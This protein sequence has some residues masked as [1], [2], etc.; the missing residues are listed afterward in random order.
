MV[1]LSIIIVNWN[2]GDLLRRCIKSVIQSPPSISYDITI[3]DN[4]STDDSVR[5]LH[6]NEV[7]ELLGGAILRVIENTDNR[8]F[9]KAN[10]QAIAAGTAPLLFLLNS[11]AEVTP[12]AIDRLISTLKSD[13]HIGACGP[14]L[15]NSDGSLQPSVSRNPP[16]AWEILVS[17][18]RL[19]KFIP[20][21][22][23][24]ELLLDSYWDHRRRRR[25]NFLTAAAILAKREMI[26]AVGGFD[27]RFHMYGE[28]NEW[29]LRIVR[30]GWT[31]LFEPE[32]TVIHHGGQS[33]LRRWSS[34]EK[35]RV[36][37]EAG[38][39]FQ[40]HCLPRRRVIANQLAHYTVCSLEQMWRR[41]RKRP[42]DDIELMLEV[43]AKNLKQ[44]LRKS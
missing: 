40:Q 20:N 42:V 4:A 21:P 44:A 33:S 41:M 9:G 31:L 39:R 43:Y 18:L 27:E 8:G 1:E 15:V 12:N 11:D 38:F 5:W 7:K 17:G 32:A 14:R 28:D 34:P 24:G 13:D 26:E 10:N 30:A 6:S 19:Y 37:I 23:R 2:G 3:V 35:L 36:Q 16:T 29:C 22:V 25:V